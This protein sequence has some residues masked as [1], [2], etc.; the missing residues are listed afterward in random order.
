MKGKGKEV[1]HGKAP[2]KRGVAYCIA[3]FRKIT[4][5]SMSNKVK[6]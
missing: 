3:I 4:K 1:G 2:N 6:A 5:S